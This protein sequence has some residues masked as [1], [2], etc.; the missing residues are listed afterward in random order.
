MIIM[1]IKNGEKHIQEYANTAYPYALQQVSERVLFVTGLSHS[2]CIVIEGDTSLILIDALDSDARALRLK[3]ILAKRTKK[4]VKTLIYTHGHP[5]HRGGSGAFA[6]SVETIIM[7]EVK[8]GKLSHYDALND[9]LKKRTSYQF[10]TSLND[11]ECITQGLGIREGYIVKYGVYAFLTPTTLLRNEVEECM[12]DGVSF[13][14]VSAPGETNDQM[15][16]YLKEDK[17][18]CCGDNYYGCFPNLY[19]LRGSQYRD[20]GA[21]IDSLSKMLEYPSEI[22]LPGHTRAIFTHQQIQEVLTN[23][24]DAISFVLHQTLFYINQGCSMSE[25]VEHVVLP[26]RFTSLPYLQEFYGCVEWAVKGIYSGYVGWFDGNPVHLHPLADHVYD[27]KL[28][29]LIGKEK[30]FAEVKD[31]FA[32]EDY[33]YVLQLCEML[34]HVAP[35]DTEVLA[36]KKKA[37]L[38]LAKLETSSCGRNYYLSCAQAY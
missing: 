19:A 6:D 37:L 8:G 38:A 28:V 17:V 4:V 13:T 11:D 34:L 12:I 16:I 5:D 20:I 25:T 36:Y 15:F 35:V 22:L 3:E 14:F 31:A 24:R 21:W 18:L 9:V 1:L 2:N 23:Y 33:T 26:S 32:K 30:V 10:G 29:A 27:E 7:S